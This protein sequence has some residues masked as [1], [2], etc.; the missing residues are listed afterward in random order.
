[1]CS[2]HDGY[3]SVQSAVMLI[4]CCTFELVYDYLGSCDF[5]NS[6]RKF[7]AI[8]CETCL[9]EAYSCKCQCT[10]HEVF[11][12][13]PSVGHRYQSVMQLTAVLTCADSVM[14]QSVMVVR[15]QLHTQCC[16]HERKRNIG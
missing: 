11:V 8:K 9:Y 1:M 14:S 15:P 6:L 12:V 2:I 3:Y 10:T 7:G 13:A 4:L 16:Y 5:E